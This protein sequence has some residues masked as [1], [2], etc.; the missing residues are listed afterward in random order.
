MIY[1]TSDLHFGHKNIVGFTDR[2]QVTDR[3][4][5]DEGLVDLW[6]SQI[7]PGDV[8]FHLGDFHF[9]SVQKSNLIQSRLRGTI[10]HVRG[11]HD[12]RDDM[13]WYRETH[14]H[15]VRTVLCHFPIASWHKQSKG[16][17]HLHGHCHGNFKNVGR[18]L[19][20]GLD[21]AYKRFGA[22]K[23][24]TDK[25]IHE[26]LSQV[27]IVSVDKHREVEEAYAKG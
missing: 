2:Q 21:S 11:N 26:I 4:A 15:N 10:F 23:F 13:P 18:S 8:V 1:F 27:P 6:N 22:H 7:T 12:R 9:G 5:H 19:D 24:F 14:L 3:E 17:Y 20:V 25:D 16:S